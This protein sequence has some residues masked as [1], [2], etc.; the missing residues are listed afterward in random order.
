MLKFE[1][2]LLTHATPPPR[3]RRAVARIHNVGTFETWKFH[4]IYFLFYLL[5]FFFPVCPCNEISVLGTYV[6]VHVHTV[7]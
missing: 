6:R 5:L 1:C 3:R 2:L 7:R 4:F